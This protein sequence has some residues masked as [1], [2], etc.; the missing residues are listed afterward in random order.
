M[1]TDEHPGPPRGLLLSLG[2]IGIILGAAI[3]GEFV[4]RLQPGLGGGNAPVS[5]GSVVM[6]SGV[7]SNTAL[8]FSPSSITLIIGIN[9]TV[10]FVNR[11]TAIHT[12]T[13]TDNSFNSGDITA[14]KSWTNTF[15]TAGNFSYYCIYH[16]S[17]MKGKVIV[18]SGIPNS[19]TVKILPN[20]G[21]DS[22]LNY[23]PST[24][25]LVVGVNNT[26]VFLNQDSV[27]HTVTASDGSFDS[28]DIHPGM[29]FIHT[30]SAGT[31]SYH[32]TYHSYM[33]GSITV[34]S[35]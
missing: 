28:G 11:D 10:T 34:V 24:F 32:C 31:Y 7:G 30:F 14:G 13:A 18:K 25:K 22:S 1:E 2:I 9:N 21:S 16:N 29:T 27:V 17:W 35:S 23:N 26:V 6:P 3:A 4:L 12:V 19:F 8:N 33:K 15:S 20:T 5:A